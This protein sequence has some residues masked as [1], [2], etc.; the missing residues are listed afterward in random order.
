MTTLG[1]LQASV[2]SM[3]AP[4]RHG[5]RAAAAGASRADDAPG[6]NGDPSATSSLLELYTRSA[7][8]FGWIATGGER[9][10]DWMNRG[11]DLEIVAPVSMGFADETPNPPQP[12]SG[13]RM[14]RVPAGDV[15]FAV[16]PRLPP[17]RHLRLHRRIIRVHFEMD[18]YDVRGRIH[19]RPG[20]EV[21]DYLLRS[22]R[23]FVPITEVEL[24]SRGEPYLRRTLPVLI[25]NSRHV[26]RLHLVEGQR[27]R[28][29]AGSN[30]PVAATTLEGPALDRA[31][32]VAAAEAEPIP[33]VVHR[34]LSELAA[35]QRDGLITRVEY[36]KKRAE[37]LARL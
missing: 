8:V 33:G 17:G 20:A 7:R 3:V 34:A 28:A 32:A 1:W 36:R 27:T 19:V 23:V 11:H 4:A 24:V 30:E 16:P 2:T 14:T 13:S 18:R 29:A 12:A 21:G 6:E 9:T 37:I 31:S 15:L 10:S 35:L 5:T 25:V 26:T 22:S